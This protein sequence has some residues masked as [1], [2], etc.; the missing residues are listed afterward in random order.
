MNSRLPYYT[1]VC[2]WLG[3]LQR[4]F[5][6]NFQIQPDSLLWWWE[7]FCRVWRKWGQGTICVLGDLFVVFGL[8][9][10]RNIHSFAKQA[11]VSVPRPTKKKKHFWQIAS[12]SIVGTEGNCGWNID[13]KLQ[14]NDPSWNLRSISPH[15][16]IS[17]LYP[18][19]HVVCFDFCQMIL[20]LLI[21]IFVLPPVFCLWCNSLE[22]FSNKVAL[23]IKSIVYIYDDFTTLINTRR[24]VLSLLECQENLPLNHLPLTHDLQV[25]FSCTPDILNGCK[26]I[27]AKIF[28]RKYAFKI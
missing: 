24:N 27:A 17:L 19:L 12:V 15:S 10:L 9:Y 23:N 8:W 14:F 22:V 21:A 2:T 7:I 1:H 26:P 28:L 6:M 20:S 3:R 25:F 13:A 5:N 4:V 18:K 16:I 11:I